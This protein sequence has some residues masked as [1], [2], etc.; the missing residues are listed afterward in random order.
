MKKVYL[1]VSTIA[2]LVGGCKSNET[3]LHELQQNAAAAC[4]PVLREDSVRIAREETKARIRSGIS[5]DANQAALDL[6]AANEMAANW[7]WV[8]P[9]LPSVPPAFTDDE[10]ASFE[11]LTAESNA[12]EAT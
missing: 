1:T 2:I 8:M 11:A 5:G 6:A 12:I 3:R 9:K 7:E 4:A 10:T